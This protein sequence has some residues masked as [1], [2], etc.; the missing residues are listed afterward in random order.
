MTDTADILSKR[1]QDLNAETVDR[2]AAEGWE[3]SRPISHETYQ[4]ALTG[5]WNIVLTPTKPVPH[6]WFGNLK[7][8]RVLGLASGGAQQMP[9]LTAAGA[10]C[11][12]L[13][14]SQAQIDS[15]ITFAA[16]E[17]YEITAIRADMTRPLPFEAAS[18]DL[19]FNPVSIC[20]IREV[21]P[22]WEEVAR[23]LKPTGTFLFGFSTPYNDIVNDD[24][25]CIVRGLPVDPTLDKEVAHQMI[26][27]DWGIQFSHTVAEVLLTTLKAGFSIDDLYEDTNGE[28]RLHELNIPSML[29][30]K[31]TKIG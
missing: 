13:D 5:N 27:G 6:S 19:V 7:N 31:A 11:T 29:A 21:A 4:Q 1:Y 28:G 10:R 20:Y 16:Q 8:T 30:V 9:I 14:Y 22:V 17:N 24:E 18:F 15:E 3:W 2:W 23:V 12:V 26:D 25:K